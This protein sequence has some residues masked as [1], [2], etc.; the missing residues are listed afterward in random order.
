MDIY[1]NRVD[2][3]QAA[4]HVPLDAERLQLLARNLGYR[5]LLEDI[6]GRH[7]NSQRLRQMTRHL[8][9]LSHALQNW[10]VAKGSESSA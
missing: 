4:P 1:P 3:T 2:P 5:A 8:S 6:Q 10:R 7:G 9:Q